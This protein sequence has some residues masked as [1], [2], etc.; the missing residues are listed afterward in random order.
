QKVSFPSPA[1]GAEPVTG[2]SIKRIWPAAAAAAILFENE[3]LTAL[4]SIQIV[5]GLRSLRNPLVLSAACSSAS[6]CANMVNKT[7]T[8]SASLG[9]ESASAAPLSSNGAALSR[10]R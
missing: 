3:G 8:W 9:G 10:V 5:F 4:Q 7:S 2:A 6:G 1:R